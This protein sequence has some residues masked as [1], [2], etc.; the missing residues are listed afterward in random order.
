ME[1]PGSPSS[2]QSRQVKTVEYIESVHHWRDELGPDENGE[3]LSTLR[4]ASRATK[5]T[6]EAKVS[7]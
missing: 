6:V 5:V 1:A 3:S 7:R 4:F 2:Q